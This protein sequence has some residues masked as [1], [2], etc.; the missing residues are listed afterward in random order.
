M[1]FSTGSSGTFR[2]IARG[3]HEARDRNLEER[4]SAAIAVLDRGYGKPSQD[5]TARIADVD[6][7]RDGE[8]VE[9]I[10]RMAL[11]LDPPPRN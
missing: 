8:L 1:P 6:A 11:G 2:R 3:V 10:A 9:V 7:L 5:I 4:A